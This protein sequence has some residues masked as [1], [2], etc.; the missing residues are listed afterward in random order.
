[1]MVYLWVK[2]NRGVIELWIRIILSDPIS[3]GTLIS[4]ILSFMQ[5]WAHLQAIKRGN[6][7][8]LLPFKMCYSFIISIQHNKN[9]RLSFWVSM[10]KRIIT[11]MCLRNTI[12]ANTKCI[13]S[14]NHW[15]CFLN[16]REKDISGV[17]NIGSLQGRKK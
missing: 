14:M 11:V 8:S 16:R 6:L 5:Y 12:F 10:T 3:T 17:T 15:D 1:M 9:V 4:A 2:H 13:L 7:V